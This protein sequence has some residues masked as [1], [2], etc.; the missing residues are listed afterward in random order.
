MKYLITS[1]AMSTWTGAALKAAIVERNFTMT[2]VAASM[3]ITD[4]RLRQL[5]AE[6]P[7]H[8]ATAAR[9]FD[10]L[11]LVAQRSSTHPT[12][13]AGGDTR[14]ATNNPADF[15]QRLKDLELE[16]ADLRLSISICQTTRIIRPVKIEVVP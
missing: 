5:L 10:A 9:V 7:V 4:R 11:D 1:V 3:G 12:Q 13:T 8:E 6:E 2:E 16:V 14:M 15:G